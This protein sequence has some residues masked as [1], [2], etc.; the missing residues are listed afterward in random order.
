MWGQY[1]SYLTALRDVIG[2][3]GLDCW[4]KYKPWEEA[5]VEGGFR[6]IH[7]EFCIVSDFPEILKIN[8]RNQPHNESGPSHRW[9]DGFEIYFLNGVKFEKELYWKV[10]KT[11]SEGGLSFADRMKIED[12]D[13]RT[14]AI[15]PKFCDISSFITEAKGELLDEVNKFDI[16]GNPVNYKLYKFLAG[17]IFIE[18]AYYCYFDCPS[19]G[20]KHL[21]GVERCNTVAEAM[22]WSMSNPDIGAVV[23]PEKWKLLVPL[24]DEN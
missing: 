16:E 17:E 12:A 4:E 5:A 1:D 20:K 8:E 22:A 2:L 10:V 19:T 14:Q 7:E 6:F 21:E 11:Q 15:N 23:T 13:Q 3:T 9:R 18:D 24:A